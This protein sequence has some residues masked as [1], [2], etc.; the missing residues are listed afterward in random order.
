M[1]PRR[2]VDRLRICRELIPEAVEVDALAPGHEPLLV[3]AVKIEMPGLRVAELRRPIA[4]AR[5]GRIDDD[6]ARDA[7]GILRRQ[8]IADHV[9]DVVRDEIGLVDLQTV[10][11][12]GNVDR[13]VLLRVAGVGMRGEPHAAQIRHDHGV[14][15]HQ[16]PRNRRPHVAAIAETVKHQG[17]TAVRRSRLSQRVGKL[18]RPRIAEREVEAGNEIDQV[19]GHQFRRAVDPDG[20]RPRSR[21][22][23]FA[24]RRALLEAPRRNLR[25]QAYDIAKRTVCIELPRLI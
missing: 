11:H 20:I 17:A 10:E 9:A 16:L 21:L 14:V 19:T 4:D 22:T 7:G 12:A 18:E 3:R 6:P 23:L 25:A 13:L 15:G 24:D 8:R 1:P 5:Q 2:L